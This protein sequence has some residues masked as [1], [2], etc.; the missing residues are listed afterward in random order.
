MIT[1]FQT[2][3]IQFVNLIYRWKKRL[4]E[5]CTFREYI[6]I[7]SGL[8]STIWFLQRQSP[9]AACVFQGHR[10][11]TQGTHWKINRVNSQSKD[12]LLLNYLVIICQ[13]CLFCSDNLRNYLIFCD[14]LIRWIHLFQ[15]ITYEIYLWTIDKCV[16]TSFT[17]KCRY[18]V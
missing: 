3:V 10:N 8:A 4:T 2:M 15:Q 5:T 6:K 11:K 9:E 14:I 17:K 7:L 16:L 1:Y 18:V 13:T 12:H